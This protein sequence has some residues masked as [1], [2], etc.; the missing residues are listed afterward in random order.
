MRTSRL[1][2]EADS[3]TIIIVDDDNGTEFG[4]FTWPPPPLTISQ[5]HMRALANDMHVFYREQRM[6]DAF[7]PMLKRVCMHYDI[8]LGGWRPPA[9]RRGGR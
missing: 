9:E 4:R 3:I 7:M 8:N 2:S 5:D 6:M 1:S